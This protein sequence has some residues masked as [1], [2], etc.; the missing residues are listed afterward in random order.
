[1]QYSS[2]NATRMTCTPPNPGES[3][4][5]SLKCGICGFAMYFKPS[6]DERRP[7]VRTVTVYYKHPGESIH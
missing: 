4:A 7:E 2:C 6:V 1:M 3:E 5:Y